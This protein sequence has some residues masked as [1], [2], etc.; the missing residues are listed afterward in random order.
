MA[1][2]RIGA[3]KAAQ[4]NKKVHGENFYKEIGKR[5]GMVRTKK[6]FAVTGLA[7]EAGARGG[8][9]SKRTF[10]EEQRKAQSDRMILRHAAPKQSIL[11]KVLHI[12]VR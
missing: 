12:G 5:G 9:K 2:T 7:A 11:H 8:R 10:T 3:A 6:G 1:G 4:T